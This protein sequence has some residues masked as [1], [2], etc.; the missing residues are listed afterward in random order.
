MANLTTDT[1]LK[2]LPYRAEQLDLKTMSN[3][4]GGCKNEG[5]EC[6]GDK[7]CCGSLLCEGFRDRFC[8]EST[9][10]IV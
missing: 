2:D 9:G 1:L 4:F 7:D 10:P 3:I 5:D 6:E 8:R